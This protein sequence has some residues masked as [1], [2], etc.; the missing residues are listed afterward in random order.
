MLAGASFAFV[1]A[2]VCVSTDSA[3]ADEETLLRAQCPGLGAWIDAKHAR[4]AKS[5]TAKVKQ[6][7]PI[8]PGLRAE[9]LQMESADQAARAAVDPSRA[10]DYDPATQAVLKVDAANLLRIEAI[11]ARHGFPT[12]TL[13]GDDGVD[14]AWMLVQHADADPAFQADALRRIKALLSSGEFDRERYAMLT[15]RVLRAQ[16]KPQRYGS[17]FEIVDG[18]WVAQAM[19]DP[20]NVDRRRAEL[21]MMPL[22]EYACVLRILNPLGKP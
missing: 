18:Q 19:E 14:A 9:L 15:D 4:D 21:G 2:C 11:V 6:A 20:A 3:A 13:V 5:T 12:R 16:G 7:A 17:Q 8:A 1:A 10:G 22:T